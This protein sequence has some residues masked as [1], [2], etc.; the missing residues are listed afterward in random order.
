MD[1]RIPELME[2]PIYR[3]VRRLDDNGVVL[4]VRAACHEVNRN[5]V[6]RAVN[7]NIYMMFRRNGIEVPFPQLTIHDASSQ[8]PRDDT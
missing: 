3:G 4:M 6:I 7:R 1:E 5:I 2:A 8:L